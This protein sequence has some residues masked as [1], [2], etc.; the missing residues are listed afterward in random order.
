MWIVV[1][2]SCTVE[3]SGSVTDLDGAAV[4]GARLQAPG[5]EAVSN[6][7]GAFRVRCERAL[8][9]FAVTHPTYAGAT[10]EIDATGLL[11]P[12]AS[13]ASLRAWPS[14]P[15]LYLE[16][17]YAAVPSP[18]LVRTAT[19][20]EQ[21]FCVPAEAVLPVAPAGT[22]L[23]DVHDVEWRLYRLDE[24]GC[25]L[26][27]STRDG[28]TY[29]S[30]TATQVEVTPTPLADGHLRVPLPAEPGRYAAA[31]WMAGFFVPRSVSPDVWEAW[32]FE[33]GA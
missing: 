27:L 26:R 20:T 30:P 15:G 29:W 32:A 1:F 4:G 11:A 23:F 5:C 33:V 9:R 10:L 3:L 21:R 13:R 24:D 6:A 25:A 16:P 28:G 31:P 12:E 14:E 8:H 22:A 17:S 2:V 7:A 19:P 18:G